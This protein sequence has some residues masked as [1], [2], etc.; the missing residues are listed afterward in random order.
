VLAIALDDVTDPWALLSSGAS[1]VLAWTDAADVADRA[2]ERFRRWHEVEELTSTRYVKENLVGE[3]PA[4]R[5]TLRDFV[6]VAHF[7]DTQILITGESGTGKELIARLVHKLDSRPDKGKLVVLD[8]TTVVPTLSG[9][10]FFGHERG[11]FTGAMS[12]REGAFAEADG[13]TLFLDEVGELSIQLQA[14]LLRVIQE[15]TYKRVGSST[16]RKTRF[17]L[18]CATNRDLKEE[19]SK[20]RFRR[21]FFYRI[22]A[23][24]GRLPSLRDRMQDIP[25]LAKHFLREASPN[26]E[27]P[28]VEP[29]VMQA[30]IKRSYP[31]NVRDLRQLVARISA[32]HVGCGPVTPGDLPPEERPGLGDAGP[33]SLS[34]DGLE[35]S[36]RR[37]LD[38]GMTMK[39]IGKAATDAAVRIVLEEEQG[40]VRRASRRLGV[41]DR[42]LQI[43]RAES[44]TGNHQPS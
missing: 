30:L 20:G 15:G 26:R 37:C 36:V 38:Q 32:R 19:E 22:A 33:M 9:S 25:L 27:P 34:Q 40:N 1:D 7:T 42:A 11:A 23:W 43:R 6:E 41:T 35:G 28:D 39:Q 16:W 10:E 8:C 18:I 12:T 29:T 4:W 3:S 14:E 2:A 5:N 21:D 44:K 31:G 24:T 13:G 17:R